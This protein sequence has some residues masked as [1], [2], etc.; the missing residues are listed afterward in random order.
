M[1][2]AKQALLAGA[3]VGEQYGD[4]LWEVRLYQ[5]ANRSTDG[6]PATESLWDLKHT[7]AFR[8]L[9]RYT[10]VEKCNRLPGNC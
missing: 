10:F 2:S 1:A 4:A 5:T 3:G 9:P 7:I 6:K 8:I